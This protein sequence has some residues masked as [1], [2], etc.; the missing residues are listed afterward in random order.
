MPAIEI[1]IG[2]SGSSV[3]GDEYTLTC[4]VTELLSGLTNM[5]T[6]QWLNSDNSPVTGND[7]SVGEVNSMDTSA[8][9]TLTFT[10]LHTSHG[11]EYTCT[12]MLK[13]P[14]V[15]EGIVN[16]DM[17]TVTVQSK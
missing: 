1:M 7:I 11:G 13:S 8:T 12:A 15:E 5:P 14:P 17:A 10:P 2:T 16:S 6:L 4:T 3:A 9:L